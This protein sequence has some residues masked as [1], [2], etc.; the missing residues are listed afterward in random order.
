VTWETLYQDRTPSTIAPKLVGDWLKRLTALGFDDTTKLHTFALNDLAEDL[1]KDHLLLSYQMGLGKTRHAIAT[2]LARDTKHTLIVLPK[3]LMGEWEKELTALGQGDDYLVIESMADAFEFRCPSCNEEVFNY[4]R[5]LDAEGNLMRIDRTCR[6]CSVEAR[7]HKRFARFNL[8]SMRDLWNVPKDS[9]HR[10]TRNGKRPARRVGGRNIPARMDLKHTWSDLLKKQ[11]GMVVVDEAYNMQNPDSNQTKAIAN[12]HAKHRMIVTGTPIRGFP[13]NILPLL[14]WAF[15]TGSDIFPDYNS[16]EENSRKR[17]VTRYGST[18]QVKKDDYTLTTKRVPRIKRADEFQAMLAPKMRRRVNTEPAVASVLRMPDFGIFPTQIELDPLHR[19]TYERW[20]E[21]FVEWYQERLLEQGRTGRSIS[22]IDMLTRMTTLAQLAA[23]PQD[24]DATFNTVSAKQSHIMQLV[25]NAVAAGRKVILY[26]EFNASLHWYADQ[27]ELAQYNPIVID[28]SVSLTRGADGKSARQRR[29]DAFQDANGDSSLLIAGTRC[30]A[31][32]LNVPEAGT[33]IFD[34]FPWVPAIQ[35]QAYSRVLR[36]AQKHFVEI[37]M[38]A[39][40]G[41]VEDYLMALCEIK[42][43]SIGEGL[44]YEL[45]ELDLEAVPDIHA[46][47][48]SLVESDAVQRIYGATA[49][50][51]RLKAQAAENM[52]D[53]DDA[54]A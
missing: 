27:P 29:L 28:G 18:I 35:Q 33:V 30:F 50:L 17:F 6:A 47:A 10:A 43:S 24:I 21:Q 52:M 34:S 38:V 42:R 25:H 37:Y 41:T 2:A 48:K 46:Y 20:A 40:L 36:P 16:R 44:D 1:T 53:S 5:V 31:E 51:D 45:V 49:W 9:P 19:A 26:S 23:V 7:R 15:G 13:E 11:F 22:Y 14:N 39:A 4:R 12:L 54:V 3:K 32:G 8:I